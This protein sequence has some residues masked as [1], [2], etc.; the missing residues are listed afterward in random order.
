MAATLAE[1]LDS[2][3]TAISN[4]ESKGQSITDGDQTKTNALLATL[5]AREERLLRKIERQSNSNGRIT[6]AEF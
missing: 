6:L 5:Y 4:V 3:Q 1:Q 2:V